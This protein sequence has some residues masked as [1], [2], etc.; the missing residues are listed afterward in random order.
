M[1]AN[2]A[3]MPLAFIGHGSP[4]NAI[5]KNEYTMNWA[6][7]AR[8]IPKPQGI[9]AISA[10]WVTEGTRVNTAMNPRIIYD[11]EGFPEA[12]YKVKYQPQ[13]FPKLARYIQSTIQE[14]V[15]PDN[16]WWVDH[17]VWSILCHMYPA[18]DIPVVVMSIDRKLEAAEYF[19]LGQTLK[20]LRSQ[21]I[22]ILGSGNIV[23]NLAKLEWEMQSGY[24]WA[25]EF[26]TYI[27]EK[28][29]QRQYDGVINYRQA[30]PHAKLAFHT[31]E[32]FAPLLYVIAASQAADTISVFNNSCILGSVSMTSYFF[33]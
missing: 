21:G 20:S 4:M 33:S 7:L 5:H 30:G 29:L 1:R 13:G 32:H 14:P 28:V 15:K 18:A 8:T 25:E 23:H 31:N 11:M 27:Q 10:H 22:L 3:K 16:T 19:Q 17:G 24:S 12:L 26:D 9:L 2:S 6:S